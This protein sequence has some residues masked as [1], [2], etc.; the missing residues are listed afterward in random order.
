MA[1]TR[2]AENVSLL[3]PLSF[4]VEGKIEKHLPAAEE[5]SEPLLL[6]LSRVPRGDTRPA[7]Y[8]PPKTEDLCARQSERAFKRGSG[9]FTVGE[10]ES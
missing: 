5:V 2:K 6:F 7:L 9:I 4:F 8:L 1:C 10:N 3:V